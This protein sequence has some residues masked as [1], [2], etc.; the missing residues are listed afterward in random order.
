MTEYEKR[1]KELFAVVYSAI[2]Y[3]VENVVL[4]DYVR[5]EIA[6]QIM[7]ELSKLVLADVVG[8]SE[9]LKCHHQ[10]MNA[11]TLQGEAM[12]KCLKCGDYVKA[13]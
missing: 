5:E 9:Q 11:G 12:K 6:N 13:L 8:R 3:N 4:P 1:E 2:P 7:P 10:Y